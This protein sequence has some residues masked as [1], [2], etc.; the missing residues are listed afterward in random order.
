M[1]RLTVGLGVSVHTLACHALANYGTK[2]QQA[3]HLPAMLGGR[4]L[5]AY[6]LSEPSSGSD[7]ASLRTKAVRDDGGPARSSGAGSG[8]TG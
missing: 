4:L 7:A 8:E 6:C 2:E 5:G 3:E 1:A